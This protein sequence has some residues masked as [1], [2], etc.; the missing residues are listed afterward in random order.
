MFYKIELKDHIRVP[1]DM[2][3]MEVEESVLKRVKTKYEGFISKDFGIV[4]DVSEVKNIGEGVIIHGDGASYYEAVFDVL[5][6]K[7]ELQEVI[8]GRIKD[9]VDFGAFINL[10][11]IEGMIHV[12]QT[13]DD[14]VSF[15]KDKT[16]A[17]KESKRTLKIGDICRARIIA[18]SY[19]DADNPKLGLTMRQQGLG[20]VDWIEQDSHK[21]VKEDKK[22]PKKEAKGRK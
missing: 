7:P 8:P 16:L 5:T 10:G 15:S 9:I 18:V 1:P 12:S 6:F 14:F 20:R 19:K 11:P 4:I 13:M 17:G 3:G 21:E 22:S 2:F